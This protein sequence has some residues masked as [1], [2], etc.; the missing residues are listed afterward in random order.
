MKLGFSQRILETCSNIIL[1]ENPSI[2][3]LFV[4]WRWTDRHDEAHSHL[5]Q[6]CKRA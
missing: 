1:H 2:G 5:L 3:S 4:P 6:F